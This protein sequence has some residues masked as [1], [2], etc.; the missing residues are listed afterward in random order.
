MSMM[1]VNLLHFPMPKSTVGSF[2][3]QPIR[4]DELALC[5][6]QLDNSFIQVLLEELRSR[7]KILGQLILS[8]RKKFRKYRM[9]R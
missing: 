6:G 3:E 1:Q 7:G 8:N 4:I 9:A 5:L 2:T